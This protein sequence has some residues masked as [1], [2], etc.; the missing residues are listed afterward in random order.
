MRGVEALKDDT[1]DLPWKISG[2]IAAY[3]SSE[4]EGKDAV[5]LLARKGKEKLLVVRSRSE[6]TLASFQGETLRRKDGFLK[7]CPLSHAN[8]VAL[9]KALPELGPKLVGL[10]T[11]V[12]LGDRLGLATPGHIRAVRGTGV[13]PVLAQQSVREMSRTGRTPE[14]VLDD[15]TWGALQEGWTEGFGADA[16]HLKTLKDIDSCA[17][18]GF[19]MYTLDPSEYVDDSAG[20]CDVGTLVTKYEAL[21]WDRLES[22]PEDMRRMYCG[23]SFQAGPFVWVLS[24]ETFLR[25][26][27]KYGRAIAHTVEMYRHLSD[28]VEEYEL[29]ISV[30]E[31]SSPTTPEEHIF[32]ASE[33]TRLEV[34]WTSLAPRFVGE[35]QKGVDYIGD[36]DEFREQFRRHMAVARKFGPYKLSIHSG[37]DKFSI[38]PVAAEESEGLV[39]LKTAGTSYLEALRAVFELSPELFRDIIALALEHYPQDRASYHVT[40]DPSRVPDPK[41]AS[42][43]ALKGLLDDFHGRQ[44]LHVTYGSVLERFGER[45]KEVLEEGEEVYYG[46]LEAHLG[47]HI[48]PFSAEGGGA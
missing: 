26:A 12:G 47:R 7:L 27:V 34:R 29:E 4:V 2:D 41:T 35:F 40:A 22:R 45:L 31:T 23:R 42:Y 25:A 20:S 15:A 10:R 37:S 5:F 3:P 1:R 18:A 13:F 21:P 17:R 36:L 43:E 24:E 6:G 39:H 9:R 46:M 19:V 14:Q 32:V 33:L 11:S 8:A 30:D 48:I 28:K 44:I 38:Y 16:D